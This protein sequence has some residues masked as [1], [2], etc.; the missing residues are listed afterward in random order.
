[1][2]RLAVN[3]DQIAVIRNMFADI[4]PDPAHAVIL[5]ELG[6]AESIV[7]HLREDLRTVNERDIR[8][9]RE[10]SKT[11][12]NIRSTINTDTIGKLLKLKPDTITF[13]ATATDL[14]WEPKPVFMEGQIEALSNQVADLRANH[15]LTSILIEPELNYIKM[16]GKLEFDYVELSTDRYTQADNLD[17]QIA[18]LE[19]INNAVLAAN[20]LGMGVNASG[21]LNQ[22]NIGDLAKITSIDDLIIGK[23]ILVRA[24]SLGYEQ[25]VR[26]FINL[27]NK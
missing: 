5:A 25:A 12:L 14:S 2:S 11:H 10:I 8:I 21:E 22:E 4:V 20:R 16:A 7:C 19:T 13:V 3:V 18:E 1:M 9:L 27:M 6:G 17:Q 24:I 15:I 23:A 26:D